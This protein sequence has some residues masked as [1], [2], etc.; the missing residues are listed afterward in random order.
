[1]NETEYWKIEFISC[2][3]NPRWIVVET[4]VGVTEDD[5]KMQLFS[6][7]GYDDAPSVFVSAE[8]WFEDDMCNDWTHIDVW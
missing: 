6:D 8:S 7:F 2:E 5:L 1:M 3:G 4:P